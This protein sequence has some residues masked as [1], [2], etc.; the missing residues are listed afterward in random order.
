MNIRVIVLLWLMVFLTIS[1][2]AKV[3]HSGEAAKA[4]D[5]NVG[6]TMV[7]P[8][9]PDPP[10]DMVKRIQECLRPHGTPT[11]MA[12]L[13]KRWS[14][15]PAASVQIFKYDLASKKVSV[16]QSLG[17][18]ASF[19]FYKAS[20][21]VVGGQQLDIKDISPDCRANTFS[22]K[23]VHEDPKKGKIAYSL[24]S[25]TPTIYASQ[26]QGNDFSIQP[27]LLVGVFRNLFNVGT[28]FNLTGPDKGHVF[29]LF[30][31]G[32]AF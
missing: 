27:A 32:A 20:D 13:G 7:L 21:L 11:Y 6:K 30:S 14:V 5:L 19:N 10:D 24:F 4:N 29:L 31:M 17:A 16:N 8:E 12:D 25:I 15:T 23:D 26:D 2:F 3:A 9:R 28:G 1:T 22:S 18:G